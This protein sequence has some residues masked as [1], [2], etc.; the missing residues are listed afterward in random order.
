M[1]E[2]V[3]PRMSVVDSTAM[4]VLR[5]RGHDNG[6]P[7]TCV[8]GAVTD[9][10]PRAPKVTVEDEQAWTPHTILRSTGRFE[11]TRCDFESYQEF[12]AFVV[13]CLRLLETARAL[14]AP[15]PYLAYV[16]T[17]PITGDGYFTGGPLGDR[18]VKLRAATQA[19][20]DNADRRRQRLDQAQM[21]ALEPLL[22][23]HIS[24]RRAASSGL[25]HWCNSLTGETGWGLT[26]VHAYGQARYS[27]AIHDGPQERRDNG[28]PSRSAG[29]MSQ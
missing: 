4:C 8:A 5:L 3:P 9:D 23:G 15:L 2:P 27:D 18:Q 20:D 29:E 6:R 16:V 28:Q 12:A 10:L 24:L 11:I 1:A 17:R 13:G 7:Y 21:Q 14:R 25:T 26:P 19:L 22:P